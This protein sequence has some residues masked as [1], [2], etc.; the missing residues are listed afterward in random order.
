ML[1][2]MP[3]TIGPPLHRNNPKKSIDCAAS[4]QF[5]AAAQL[6]GDAFRGTTAVSF[7]AV[8]FKASIRP[9]SYILDIQ[10]PW[11]RS[12]SRHLHRGVTILLLLAPSR[13]F[14]CI[15]GM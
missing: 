1:P 14:S 12:V 3:L 9:T 6:R 13:T 2:F 11:N 5:Y 4:A 10:S 8:A 7:F 15:D